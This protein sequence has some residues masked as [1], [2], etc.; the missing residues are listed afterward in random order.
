M[1]TAG[2]MFVLICLC[3][4]VFFVVPSLLQS[5]NSNATHQP[6]KTVNKITLTQNNYNHASRK[7]F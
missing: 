4:V 5:E 6:V 3:C 2:P 1:S 7:D